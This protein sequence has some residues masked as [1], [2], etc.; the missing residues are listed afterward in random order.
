MNA[1]DLLSVYYARLV[2][3]GDHCQ[4]GSSLNCNEEEEFI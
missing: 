4:K 1:P 3:R 2:G